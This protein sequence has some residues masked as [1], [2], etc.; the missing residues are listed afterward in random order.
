MRSSMVP[1]DVL[2]GTQNNFETANCGSFSK[3]IRCLR[4]FRCWPASGKN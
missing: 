1:L 3:M 2:K 4:S